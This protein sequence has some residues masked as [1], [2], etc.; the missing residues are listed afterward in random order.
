MPM[1][2]SLAPGTACTSTPAV[3]VPGKSV[4][5]IITQSAPGLRLLT[6]D[7]PLYKALQARQ[8]RPAYCKV[9]EGLT[10]TAALVCPSLSTISR[11]AEPSSVI[12][13]K[14]MSSPVAEARST[15]TVCVPVGM[16]A[17]RNHHSAAPG[18]VEL[19]VLRCTRAIL[20]PP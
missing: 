13:T 12:L 15:L 8:V 17:P 19:Q 4:L 18:S 14:R 20:T 2:K 1:A 11:S 10:A 9:T 16:L 3:N 7:S 6:S 5:L